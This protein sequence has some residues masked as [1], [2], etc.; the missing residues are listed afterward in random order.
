LTETLSKL[1]PQLQVTQPSHS[2]VLQ[3]GGCRICGGAHESGCC[4]PLDEAA[5]KVNYM[6]NQHRPGFNVGGF[7]FFLARFQL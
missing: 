3:V 4:I 6:V 1:P 5:Q 7:E 2:E